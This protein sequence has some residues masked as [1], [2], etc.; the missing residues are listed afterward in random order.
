MLTIGD[1]E[2]RIIRVSW[3]KKHF[4]IL[5]IEKIFL[6]EWVS[7]L[8][9]RQKDFSTGRYQHQFPRDCARRGHFRNAALLSAQQ[10]TRA[11]EKSF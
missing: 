7:E 3:C 4:V 10:E 8:L 5:S 1:V 6:V 9:A 2:L 11:Y